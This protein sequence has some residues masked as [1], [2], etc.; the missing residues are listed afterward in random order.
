MNALPVVELERKYVYPLIRVS[1]LDPLRPFTDGQ[2]TAPYIF[3]IPDRTDILVTPVRCKTDLVTTK[4][5]LVHHGIAFASVLEG[6]RIRMGARWACGYASANVVLL[7]DTGK[8]GTC[9]A[10][11]DKVDPLACVYRCLDANGD[12]LYIG[13]TNQ[14]HQRFRTHEYKSPWW[15]QVADIELQKFPTILEARVAEAQAIYAENPPCNRQG[16]SA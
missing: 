1:Y 15:P 12:L 8:L 6:N 16:R 5:G 7:A 13:S 3:R 9:P 11:K 14:R 10:C 4:A 2:R